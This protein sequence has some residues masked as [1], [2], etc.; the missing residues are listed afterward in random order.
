M[1]SRSWK[2]E[3]FEVAKAMSTSRALGTDGKADILHDIFLVDTKLRGSWDSAGKWYEDLSKEAERK[4]KIPILTLRKPKK[5][6]R[7][8]VMDFD[9]FVS[10]TKAA[11]WGPDVS[12]D[13]IPE[14]KVE[15]GLLEPLDFEIQ[16]AKLPND[17][18][19][20]EPL[21]FELQDVNIELEPLDVE[22]E[23]ETEV[24]QKTKKS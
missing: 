19:L 4:G 20:L 6:R 2:R 10:L 7:L 9:N 21:D 14:L 13:D 22:L 12:I 8:V 23:T 15:T 17:T 24:Y 11:G 5:H 18:G 16:A 1:T 3:E